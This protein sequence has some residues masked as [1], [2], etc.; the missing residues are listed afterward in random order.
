MTDR[1]PLR[2]GGPLI[3]AHATP[4]QSHP[5]LRLVV[6]G[7]AATSYDELV[8][9][10]LQ[11]ERQGDREK[12]RDSFH[13]ALHSLTPERSRESSSLLRWIGRDVHYT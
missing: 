10:G 9:R 5:A 4:V 11:L 13:E 2:R 1:L 12:A 3:L 6:P 8:E 7:A